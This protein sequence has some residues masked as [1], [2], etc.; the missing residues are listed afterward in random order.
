MNCGHVVTNLFVRSRSGVLLSGKRINSLLCGSGLNQQ[1]L[2]VVS[3]PLSPAQTGKVI[4]SE[5]LSRAS[6][7]N[8]SHPRFPIPR[9]PK[10]SMFGESTFQLLLFT[11]EFVANNDRVLPVGIQT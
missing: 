4:L 9:S 7:C 6:D 5:T 1:L 10:R 11:L 8:R 2:G 3:M